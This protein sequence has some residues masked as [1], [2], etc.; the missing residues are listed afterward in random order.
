MRAPAPLDNQ[1]LSVSILRENGAEQTGVKRGRWRVIGDTL[2]EV[3]LLQWRG[4]HRSGGRSMSQH[5]LYGN[6]SSTRTM[7]GLG[8]SGEARVA[9]AAG[10][11][12]GSAEWFVKP[13]NWGLGLGAPVVREFTRQALGVARLRHPHIV[14]VV[15]A[16]SAP[17]GTPFVIMERLSGATL[18]ERAGG[19]LIPLA[20]LLPILRGVAAGLAAAQAV[21]MA[22]RELR[23]DNIFMADA[24]G[25]AYGFPKLLDFG[26]VEL[27]AGATELG[28]EVAA[29]T[30]DAVPPEQRQNLTKGDAQSDQYAVAALAYRFLAV[31]EITT[32][33]ELVLSRAMSWHPAR[34]FDSIVVFLEA[35]DNAARAQPEAPRAK[36]VADERPSPPAVEPGSLTQQF[37][38]EGDRLEQAAEEVSRA[39]ATIPAE[40]TLSLPERV[41]RSRAPMI[42]TLSLALV[43]SVVIGWTAVT[44]SEVPHSADQSVEAA[45]VPPAVVAPVSAVPGGTAARTASAALRA[46][47]RPRATARLT[48]PLTAPP[49]MVAPALSFQAAP[50]PAATAAAIP[51]P[52]PAVS[53]PAPA[54]AAPPPAAD[55]SA[56]AAVP[57]VPEGEVGAAAAAPPPVEQGGTQPPEATNG[58]TIEERPPAESATP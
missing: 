47:Q 25:Y 38:V 5:H 8:L 22:H 56:A 43:S 45:Q 9:G 53:T 40:D 55:P 48:R 51:P 28:R 4:P 37:F 52:G 16:G 35:L 33:V 54:P 23:A 26:V 24:A 12:V 6:E 29:L 39:G 46:S 36:E 31:A 32:A 14:Q 57:T 50:T 30:P 18:E 11:P 20:E 27:T 17:D 58:A 49:P 10:P 34:R 15:D 41:P 44:L 3:R 13:F 21:G 7:I 42:A 19:T 2:A 1:C